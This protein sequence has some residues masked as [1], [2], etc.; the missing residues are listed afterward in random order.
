[1]TLRGKILV[2]FLLLLLALM[3]LLAALVYRS[4]LASSLQQVQA[5]LGFAY[6]VLDNELHSRRQTQSAM[7][8]LI[9]KD[10]TLLGEIADLVA[11]PQQE[12]QSLSAALESFAA[13]SQAG[14]ALVLA[15]D[16][17]VLAGTSEE[18][19]PGARLPW[20]GLFDGAEPDNAERLVVLGGRVLH[21]NLTPIFAP[22]PN[23]MG[24]LLMAFELDDAAAGHLAELIGADVA[25]LDGAPGAYRVLASNLSGLP[26]AELGGSRLPDSQGVFRFP[27]QGLE[28][29]AL[30]APLAGTNGDLQVLLMRSLSTE[31]AHF[32][33][34]QWQLAAIFAAALLL[35]G[36]GALW[37]ANTISRPLAQMVENV[38][39]I[40]AGDYQASVAT[41]A[42]GEVGLLAREFAAMQRGIAEREQTIGFLAYRDPLTELANRNRFVAELQQALRQCPPGAGV[43]VLLMDLDNFKDLNDTLGH[44]AGD[45]LLRL[46][47]ARLQERLRD[48]E[49]LARL[50]GD[51]FAVLLPRCNPGDLVPAAEHYRA[52]L[53]EP[54]EVRGI[55]MTL[56]ATLGIA[57]Y[58]DHGESAGSLLQHAEVAMYWGKA[59]HAPHTL[60]R[61]E[62]D[63]HSLVRLAL[64]SE[65]KGAVEQGQLSLYFQPKLEIRSRRLL[66]VE[67]L[68]RWIHPVHGFV[69]PDEFIPL[70][71][72]TGNVCALTRWVLRTA[73]AQC[74]A[75]HEQGLALKVAV[76]VSA[77]DLADPGFAG[78]IAALLEEHGVAPAGLVVE[79]TESAVMADPEQALGQLQQLCELG[80]RLSIDDYGTG[81]SSMAQLKRL[82]VHELKIDKSFVQD[83]LSNPDDDIIVRSTVELGHNMGLRVVAEGVE[84][85]AILQRLD[86]LGCD[87]AQGYL[88]SKP[89]APAAFAEWLEKTHWTLP[90]L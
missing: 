8:E 55:G 4:T 54:F 28:Q 9:A 12:A 81:Y 23:L 79:I 88:L 36:L 74:R 78:H 73:L 66:G 30:R 84:T 71:E 62:L 44:E 53:L 68:V 43:A 56:N 80:V 16:G 57:L 39:R 85:D 1:M 32:R 50:G 17:L 59:Q 35:A 51:E 3:G 47:A 33:P 19:V 65:L 26:R 82:P 41:A 24:W 34:L 29:L 69:P 60:Y 11:S 25:L 76:N 67:C 46:L 40:A 5:R 90:R 20:G 38:R 86:Q 49:Q 21:V 2:F 89:L 83:L 64:M 61:P 75:W 10:F 14:F 22:R 31:L 15:P 18:L 58:P 27:L 70:A 13:R 48:G 87:I 7:A 37:I 72:Q 77:L 63:R 45:Q 52:A 42:G 6:R